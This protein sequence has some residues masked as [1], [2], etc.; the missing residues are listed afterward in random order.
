[1]IIRFRV[2]GRIRGKGRPRFVR[3][4]G[5][6]YTDAKTKSTEAVVRSFAADAMRGKSLMAGPVALSVIMRINHPASWPKKRKAQTTFVTGKPDCDNLEKAIADACNGIVYRDD[7]QIAQV[8][9]DRRYQ[10]GPEYVDIA[11]YDLSVA[12]WSTA[13]AHEVAA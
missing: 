8:Q 1:M 7:S 3:A 5:R 6:T 9:F 4:T 11:I 13:Q 10:D 12:P 2:P